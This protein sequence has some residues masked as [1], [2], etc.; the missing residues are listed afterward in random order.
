MRFS[1]AFSFPTRRMALYVDVGMLTPPCAPRLRNLCNSLVKPTRRDARRNDYGCEPW[2]RLGAR[3]SARP[4]R[5]APRG[6][7]RLEQRNG[8]DAEDAREPDEIA[9]RKVRAA[10]D[11]LHGLRL[12]PQA[13]GEVLLRPAVLTPQLRDSR[14]DVGDDL[15]G[16]VHRVERR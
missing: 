2:Q 10:F 13:V 1:L 15:L 16:L 12:H 14:A 3:R 6:L 8:R 9:D 7:W 11:A 5:A 4:S